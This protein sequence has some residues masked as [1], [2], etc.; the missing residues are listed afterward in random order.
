VRQ[1]ALRADPVTRRFRLAD[2]GTVER[3]VPGSFFEFISRDR[4]ADGAL[5]LTFDT[6]NAQGIF[7]MTRH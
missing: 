7:T 1:T 5:D 4:L 6:G 2:G 3:T